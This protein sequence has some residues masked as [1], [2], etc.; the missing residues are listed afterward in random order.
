M[1]GFLPKVPMFPIVGVPDAWSQTVKSRSKFSLTR[2][3][4]AVDNVTIGVEDV[5]RVSCR[6]IIVGGPIRILCHITP[7]QRPALRSH[8]ALIG[9][10][11]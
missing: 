8:S 10:L 4:G 11:G 6:L 2:N 5:S 3:F 1:H 9:V 7:L